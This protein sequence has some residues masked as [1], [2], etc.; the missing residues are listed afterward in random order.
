MILVRVF[1]VPRYLTLTELVVNLFL[2]GGVGWWLGGRWGMASGIAVLLALYGSAIVVAASASSRSQ[3][4]GG[5]GSSA[6]APDASGSKD[7]PETRK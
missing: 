7:P 6:A 4:C 5:I 3:A 2:Y 1:I